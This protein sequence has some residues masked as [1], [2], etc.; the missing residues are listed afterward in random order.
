MEVLVGKVISLYSKLGVASIK[1]SG[2]LETG[3]LIHIKGCT[4][5]FDQKVR[6][7][8][9]AH[10]QVDRADAGDIAGLKVDDYVRKHD[11]IYRK[12]KDG[13]Q[14]SAVGAHQLTPET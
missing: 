9:I 7:M 6:S 2:S 14:L 5:D 8:Q 12:I 11:C 4:T 1:L 13:D 10:Q 3:N